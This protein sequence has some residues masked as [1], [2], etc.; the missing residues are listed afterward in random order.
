MIRIGIVGCGRI[1]NAH[2]QGYLRLREAGIDNFRITALC[3]RNPVDAQMFH[4]RGK[5]PTPRPP[6]VDPASGDPLA[7]PHTYV[8]DLHTDVEVGIFDDYA[9]MIA[10]GTVDAI[11]DFTTL[12]LHH[13]VGATALTA[14][15]HL[16]TQKPLAITVKA[17]QGLLHLAEQRQRTFG[18]FENVRQLEIVRAQHW[19]VASGLIGVPQFASMGML[20]GLWSP[21]KIVA[22]TPWRHQ[23]LRAGGGGSIDIGV[24]QMDWLRYVMGEVES[25]SAMTGIYAPQRTHTYATGEQTTVVA[26][27][28]DTYM[29]TI[30]FANASLAQVSWSWAGLP[31]TVMTEGMPVFVGSDGMIRNDR[32]SSRTGHESSLLEVFHAHMTDAH[33]AQWFPLGLT[34]AAAISQYDWLQAITTMTQ[35]ET[36]AAEG[37]RDLAAAYAILESQHSRRHVTLSEVLAGD[38]SGYQDPINA[39]YG[40]HL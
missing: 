37:L 10:S 20:G 31:Q 32:I 19:A 24:H 4:T 9:E 12:A 33:R 28:D 3:A 17:A 36:S 8:S 22:E 11:N 25:V 34:D 6:V 30:R 7:A 27:V 40:L 14:G 1:L 23:K 15:M 18:V 5:G 38:V 13:Q 39:Y 16:L 26:D 29:A 21:N 2:L 35:P